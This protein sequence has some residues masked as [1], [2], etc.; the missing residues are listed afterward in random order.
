LKN[1]KQVKDAKTWWNLRRPEIVEDFDREI[2]GRVPSNTPRVNWEVLSTSQEK[3]GDFPVVVKKLIGHVDNSSY[4]SI[5]VDIDLT[6]TTPTQATRPVP[7]MM[8][9]GFVF[10]PG[11]RPPAGFKPP[12]GPTWQQQLLAKGWGYAILIPTSAQADNGAGLTKGIIGLCNKGQPR[13]PDDWGA[14]RAWAWSASRALDYLETDKSVNAKQ[15]GIEGL[16]RYGKAALLTMAYDQR[17]AIGFIGS[18]GAGGA[19]LFRRNFGEL[20]ENLASSYAY[21]WMSGN[22]IKYAGPLTSKDLPVDS[23]ELIALCAPRPIFISY[24]ASEGPGAEGQWV[25]QR[26]SFMAA[27]AAG[28]VFRLLGKKD[29][30][31]SE[32]PPIETALIEGEL[33]FRQHRGGHTTGPNWPTFL[34][35]ASRYVKSAPVSTNSAQ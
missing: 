3:N 4:P 35:F 5:K 20:V 6:L 2:Y 32:F 11:F 9:F 21:H 34:K 25:D 26:G 12:P 10:P 15:V 31:T 13:K 17:F 16:S 19:K 30:G 27:V 23:H 14:L 8:N 1:G 29:L 7:V 24:G 22:L 33:A 28:P 18:S